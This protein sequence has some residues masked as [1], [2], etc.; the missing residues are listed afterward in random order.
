MDQKKKAERYALPAHFPTISIIRKRI[1]GG[2]ARA[3]R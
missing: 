2:M 3:I 1:K